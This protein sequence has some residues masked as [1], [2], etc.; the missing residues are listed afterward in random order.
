MGATS[1][2]I[3]HRINTIMDSSHILVM[4]AGRVGQFGSPRELLEGGGLFK[5]LVDSHER[6]HE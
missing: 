2:V 1:I 6:S 5:E 3:A 4:D